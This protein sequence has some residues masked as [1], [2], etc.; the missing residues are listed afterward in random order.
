[1]GTFGIYRAF[2]ITKRADFT[3]RTP[4]T[5]RIHAE[6]LSPSCSSV[7]A[8]FNPAHVTRAPR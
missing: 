8:S 7:H 3:R 2:S 1:M 6:P 5:E 4:S